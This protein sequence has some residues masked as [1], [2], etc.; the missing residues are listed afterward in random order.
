LEEKLIKMTKFRNLLGYLYTDINNEKI[1][2]I[3]QNNLN[4][5][6]KHIISKFKVQ[7]LNENKQ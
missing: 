6:K 1:Y 7:L 3:L 5:F 2:E 4:L